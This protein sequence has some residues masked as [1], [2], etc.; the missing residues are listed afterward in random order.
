MFFLLGYR[1]K[2][3]ISAEGLKI[4]VIAQKCGFAFNVFSAMLNGVRK[5]KAEE[6]FIICKVLNVPL[7]KFVSKELLC[8]VTS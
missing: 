1:I 2:E 8:Q 3:Y 4:G 5:I 6:Y 7:D